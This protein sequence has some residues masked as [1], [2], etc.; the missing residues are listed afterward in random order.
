MHMYMYMYMYM[1]IYIYIDYIHLQIIM[2]K[3]AHMNKCLYMHT[4]MLICIHMHT[5]TYASPLR[6]MYAYTC[7]LAHMQAR[8]ENRAADC[9]GCWRSA[10]TRWKSQRA[11]RCC[12]LRHA[13]ERRRADC[14]FSQVWVVCIVSFKH[15]CKQSRLC[16]CVGMEGVH[17]R[18]Y[19]NMYVCSQTRYLLLVPIYTYIHHVCADVLGSKACTC[20]EK[21]YLESAL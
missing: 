15:T 18:M 19:A 9:S 3:S 10:H 8:W 20:P 11:R 5:C 7:T 2:L 14:G 17:V 16:T 13:V 12:G 6:L 4:Y 1:Y 21:N